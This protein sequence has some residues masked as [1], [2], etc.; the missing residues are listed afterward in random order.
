MKIVNEQANIQVTEYELGGV[1]QAG[2]MTYMVIK[3]DDLY[4]HVNLKTGNSVSGTYGSLEE[5]YAWCDHTDERLVN[6]KLV[7]KDGANQ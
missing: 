2:D 6:A 1:Y 5:L 7:I 3:T 4:Q